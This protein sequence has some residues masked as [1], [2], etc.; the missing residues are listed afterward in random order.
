MQPFNIFPR[1]K[2]KEFLQNQLNCSGVGTAS[3]LILSFPSLFPAPLDEL[4]FSGS[5]FTPDEISFVNLTS[6]SYKFFRV[7]RADVDGRSFLIRLLPV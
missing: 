4:Y 1:K 7:P 3:A 6:D 2:K 5:H